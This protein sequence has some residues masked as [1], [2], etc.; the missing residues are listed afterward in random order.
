MLQLTF[1]NTD[2]VFF[3]FLRLILLPRR[4]VLMVSVLHSN[5][6]KEFYEFL[7]N[8]LPI[9]YWVNYMSL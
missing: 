2:L 7:V 8:E 5:A 1:Y 6:D 4:K 9:V 3:V